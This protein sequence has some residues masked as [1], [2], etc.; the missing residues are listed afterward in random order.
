[1]GTDQSNTILFMRK[2]LR[3]LAIYQDF[4]RNYVDAA[5]CVSLKKQIN[6]L[7]TLVIQ[8]PCQAMAWQLEMAEVWRQ[9]G[10]AAVFGVD[11]LRTIDFKA[12][13]R[14]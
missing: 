3:N 11:N 10:R 8:T 14:G 9:Q 6:T 4:W 13:V 12:Q 2:M 5:A 1:M 7:L